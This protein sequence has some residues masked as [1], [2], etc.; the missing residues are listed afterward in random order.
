MT[1][2]AKDN[3][4]QFLKAMVN[5]HPDG[6]II[7]LYTADALK[8]YCKWASENNI[9]VNL[10]TETFNEND[11]NATRFGSIIRSLKIKGITTAHKKKANMKIFNIEE[12]KEHFKI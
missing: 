6:A 9:T 8:E 10:T 4:M 5:M 12:I 7:R 11:M 1:T 3:V 2:K